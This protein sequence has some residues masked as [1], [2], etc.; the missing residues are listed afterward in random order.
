MFTYYLKLAL[1]A[2]KR[3]PVLST[4]MVLAIALGLATAMTSFTVLYRLSNNP[5]PHKSDV[6]YAVQLDNWDPQSPY[7]RERGLP[8]DQLTHGDTRRL[9]AD[10]KGLRQ[11]GMYQSSVVVVPADPQ[12]RPRNAS[13]RVTGG[14]LFAMFDAPFLHGGGWSKEDEQREARVAVITRELAERVFKKTD[15]VGQRIR[16]D[17]EDFTITGVLDTWELR[18]R[19]YDT[20]NN[21]L[22]DPEDVFLP[23]TVATAREMDINGN[24]NCW[25]PPSA[26]GY[27]G[28]MD[29]ECIMTQYWVELP[30]AAAVSAYQ[31][32]LDAYVAEQRKAGRFGRPDNH[33]ITPVMGWLAV[34]NVVPDDTRIFVG[35][36]V[37]FL[38]VCLLNAA[39]LLLSKFL[40]KSGEIGLRRALGAR[41][42]AIFAQHLTESGLIG[43]LGAVCGLLL[44]LGGLALV[45]SLM[46]NFDDVARLDV[47]LFGMLLVTAVAGAVAAGAYP[48]WRACRI[49]PA[50]QLKTQ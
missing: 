49:E 35:V 4:L 48:A 6:L 22:D 30:D 32:Y 44:T 12:V 10:A 36:G 24:I 43:A 29:S 13:V 47:G 23:F 17:D 15:V 1:L 40:R 26:P 11:A 2:L 34:N 50:S 37:A 21:T 45:R 27:R 14:D 46:P 7:D 5:I 33:R 42:G 18:P 19:F 20:T 25:Q 3:T 8:P 31:A 28:L 9:M 16:F 39:G 38:I 41:R